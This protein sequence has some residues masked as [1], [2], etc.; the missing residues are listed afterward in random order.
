MQENRIHNV[1]S[2]SLCDSPPH[3][4]C[5]YTLRAILVIFF[6]VIKPCFPHHVLL[7]LAAKQQQQPN[8][9]LHVIEEP[10]YFR[11]R[12]FLALTLLYCPA[13]PPIQLTFLCLMCVTTHPISLTVYTLFVCCPER[14]FLKFSYHNQTTNERRRKNSILWTLSLNL[15]NRTLVLIEGRLI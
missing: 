13:T 5:Q 15:R 10:P 6:N 3:P 7:V 1:N 14:T 2:F 4:Q 9:T 12:C 11:Q 8:S